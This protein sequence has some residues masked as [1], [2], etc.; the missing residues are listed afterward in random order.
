MHAWLA[1]HFD[2]DVFIY[3]GIA[4]WLAWGAWTDHTQGE[5]TEAFG[6]FSAMVFIIAAESGRIRKAIKEHRCGKP[7]A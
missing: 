1:K 2:L 3:Y 5:G 7:E 4:A 6:L